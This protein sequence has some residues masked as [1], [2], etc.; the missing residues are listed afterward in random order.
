MSKPVPIPT[1]ETARYWEGCRAHE[2]VLPRCGRCGRFVF[3]PRPACPYCG[4][5]DEMEWVRTSGRGRL[6]SYVIQ[7]VPAPGY[8][9]ETPFV[10]AL[11]ALEE[12]VTMLSNIVGVEPAPESLKLGM[13]LEVAFEERGELAVPVFRPVSR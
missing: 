9:D 5:D 6:A 11:V 4:L 3:Y 13:E 8:E 10:I 2:L 1:P 7:H 12:G